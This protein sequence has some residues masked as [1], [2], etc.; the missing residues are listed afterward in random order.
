MF[1]ISIKKLWKSIWKG[2]HMKERIDM[3][4]LPDHPDIISAIQTGYPR[5]KVD[6]EDVDEV[7]ENCGEPI[8]YDDVYEDGGETLCRY[9]LLARYKKD[10]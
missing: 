3:F 2:R 1:I 8:D 10:V 6:E 5:N 9:C 4:D 7:C